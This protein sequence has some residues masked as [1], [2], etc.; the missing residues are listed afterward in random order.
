MRVLV[1]GAAGE[2]GRGLA[3]RLAGDGH[4]LGLFDRDDTVARVAAALAAAGGVL[5][6]S[7]DVTDDK[8][9]EGAVDQMVARFGGVDALVHCAGVGGPATDVVDT[10]LTAFRHVVEVNLVGAFLMARAVARRL[11]AQ[12]SGGV[13]VN[14]G[15]VFGEQAVRGAAGYC[16]AK[17]GLRQLT[18]SLALELAPHRIRVNTV[19]PGNMATGM[20][21]DELRARALRN[22]TDFER[23]QD[24]VLRSIPLGRFGTGADLAGAVTWLLS[25][26]ADYVTGQTLAVNGGILLS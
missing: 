22:R 2:L 8:A 4:A 15:S 7:G 14:V 16:A 21:W 17:G 3:L 1:T 24:L 12:G 25:A 19:A 11:I 9:V 10:P 20:H 23:E 26:D 5:A 6:C 18:Q 13:V